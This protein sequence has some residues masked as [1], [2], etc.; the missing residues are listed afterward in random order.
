MKCRWIGSVELLKP[1]GWSPD[2]FLESKRQHELS[3]PFLLQPG[4]WQSPALPSTLPGAILTLQGL[5]PVVSQLTTQTPCSLLQW[6]FPTS[7]YVGQPLLHANKD[8]DHLLR[9]CKTPASNKL[10]LE[11]RK[12][13]IISPGTN[14]REA[15][16][17]M[18]CTCE[19]GW[20]KER[21]S[22]QPRRLM[23]KLACTRLLDIWKWTES[24]R[25][26]SGCLSWR[27]EHVTRILGNS[28]N[29]IRRKASAEAD[30]RKVLRCLIQRKVTCMQCPNP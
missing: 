19:H 29:S 20:E 28:S 11:Q 5:W 12:Q 7:P 18:K 4:V 25:I 21:I 30:A 9:C 8:Y 13:T 1:L 14:E 6:L 17:E 16:S 24:D 26:Y 2:A 27:G 22:N 10:W 15:S 23:L 3:V